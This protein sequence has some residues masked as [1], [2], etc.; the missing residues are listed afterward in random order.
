MRPGL[1]TD[2]RFGRLRLDF[3]DSSRVPCPS[4]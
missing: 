1:D 4:I 3:I 2:T